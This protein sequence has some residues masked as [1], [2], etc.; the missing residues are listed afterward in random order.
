MLLTLSF[1][2]SYF[3]DCGIPYLNYAVYFVCNL[4]I[5]FERPFQK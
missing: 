4:T 2:C 3:F 1:D 5:D